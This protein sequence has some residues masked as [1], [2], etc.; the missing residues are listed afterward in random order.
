MV[1]QSDVDQ[2]RL[3]GGQKTNSD[4]FGEDVNASGSIAA[5][6]VDR[7]RSKVGTMLPL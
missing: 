7:V 5:D 2:T 4:N 1:D 6:D 3:A